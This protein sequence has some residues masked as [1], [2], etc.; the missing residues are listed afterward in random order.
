MAFW[1]GSRP[2]PEIDRASPIDYLMCVMDVGP[3][4]LQ[5]GAVVRFA[6]GPA[7]ALEDLRQRVAERARATPKLR[8]RLVKSP[9][10][11]GWPVWVDDPGFDIAAH[12]QQMSCP[13]PRDDRALMSLASRL[14]TARLPPERPLWLIMLVTELVDESSALVAVLHHCLA[15][16]LGG[17]AVLR[18]LADGAPALATELQEFPRRRPAAGALF[19]N[20]VTMKLEAARHPER[21]IRS[22]RGAWRDVVN[23]ELPR[24][25]RSSLI[26]AGG[27]RRE[28]VIARAQLRQVRAAASAA[29]GRPDDIVLC[30]AAGALGRVASARGEKVT[31]VVAG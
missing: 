15:D 25:P 29:G 2:L 27:Q 17:V 5:V 14:V 30:A 3:I 18:N 26:R 11:C 7:V 1:K 20:A 22:L 13:A 31:H 23:H 8:Q 10:G 16:G 9:L 24:S 12:V 21:L 19:L 6:S 28:L 4:P